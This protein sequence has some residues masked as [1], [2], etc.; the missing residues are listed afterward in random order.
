M[1]ATNPPSTNRAALQAATEGHG[2]LDVTVDDGEV[3][4]PGHRFRPTDERAALVEAVSLVDDEGRLGDS[5]LGSAAA[6]TVPAGMR[7]V[8]RSRCWVRASN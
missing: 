4:R 5:V 6:G 8:T 7:S 1:P 2:R 3:D